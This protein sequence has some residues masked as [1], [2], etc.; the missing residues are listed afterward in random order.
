MLI[1]VGD[2]EAFPTISKAIW[3][4]RQPLP[5]QRAVFRMGGWSLDDYGT[6]SMRPCGL[7]TRFCR[8]PLRKGCCV[9]R[10]GKP[11]GPY[12]P[13]LLQPKP[14]NPYLIVTAIRRALVQLFRYQQETRFSKCGVGGCGCCR[15]QEKTLL[16]MMSSYSSSGE[17]ECL[18]EEG[19]RRSAYET[20]VFPKDSLGVSVLGE[21]FSQ[22]LSAEIPDDFP[23]RT[24]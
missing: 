17:D 21:M 18:G 2:Q 11:E 14:H 12:T 7:Q 24:L 13:C 10:W 3:N 16:G 9:W 5:S 1:A 8:D 19:T 20:S 4:H 22:H 23:P 15:E 6:G